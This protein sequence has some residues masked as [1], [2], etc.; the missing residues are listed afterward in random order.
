MLA[1]KSPIIASVMPWINFQSIPGYGQH[2]LEINRSRRAVA[3][4]LLRKSEDYSDSSVAPTGSEEAMREVL[5]K[6]APVRPQT[7]W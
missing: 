2:V 6:E 4:L 1:G 3:V 5:D 7:A